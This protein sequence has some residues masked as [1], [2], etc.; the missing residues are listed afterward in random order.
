MSLAHPGCDNDYAISRNQKGGPGARRFNEMISPGARC[1]GGAEAPPGLESYFLAFFLVFF[2]FAFFAF[3]AFLAIASSFGFNGW[4][5]DT[6]HARGGPSLATASVV[7]RA[8]SQATASRC[9]AG[10]ITL[11]TA[12]VG[13]LTVFRSRDAIHAAR[14]RLTTR[15]LHRSGT[16]ARRQGAPRHLHRFKTTARIASPW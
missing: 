11:S 14:P 8:D 4:K 5:R 7:I 6:R 15:Q 12:V 3:F 13:F 10:V 16:G 2:A 1:P 9:H